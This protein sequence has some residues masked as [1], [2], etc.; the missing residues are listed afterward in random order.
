MLRILQWNADGLSTK[1]QELRDRLAA[2]SIDVCLIQKTKLTE[3]DA[4]RLSQAT[5]QSELTAPALTG[6][7]VYSPWLKK[8]L[9]SNVTLK[10]SVLL[11]K[12]SPYKSSCP[13]EDGR[14]FTIFTWHQ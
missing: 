10:T 13:V 6:E 11:W 5:T 8:A 7:E 2:E 14:R 9:F 4:S 3:K 12:N 1:V